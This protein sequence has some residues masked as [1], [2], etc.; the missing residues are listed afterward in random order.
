MMS[1][2][3]FAFNL[4]ATVYF[5]LGSRLEERR[6]IDSFGDQYR[7]YQT[8]VRWMLPRLRRK[9]EQRSNNLSIEQ[10]SQLR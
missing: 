8:Q 7:A 10:T 5:L 1:E 3:L 4:G 2:A 6:L 9:P